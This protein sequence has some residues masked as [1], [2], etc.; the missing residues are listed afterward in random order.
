LHAAFNP[1]IQATTPKWLTVIAVIAI[2]ASHVRN[3]RFA[4]SD[5]PLPPEKRGTR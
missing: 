5:R 2:A 4:G 1:S 3:C